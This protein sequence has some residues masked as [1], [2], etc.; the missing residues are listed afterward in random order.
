MT[1]VVSGQTQYVSSGVTDTGDLV[2]YG[3]VQVVLSG[4]TTINTDDFGVQTLEFDGVGSVTSVESGGVQNVDGGNSI[5]AVVLNGG[6]QN[7]SNGGFGLKDQIDVGGTQNLSGGEEVDALIYGIEDVY[8]GGVADSGTVSGGPAYLNIYSGGSG[9]YNVAKGAGWVAVYSG[10]AAFGTYV[11]SGGAGRVYSSGMTTSTTVFTQ[12]EEDVLFGGVATAT[13]V[14]SGGAAYIGQGGASSD[15]VIFS[16]GAEFVSGSANTPT[17]SSAGSLEVSSGGVAAFAQVQAFSS[18]TVD[19]GGVDSSG[20]VGGLQTVFGKTVKDV[21]SGGPANEYVSN[22][23]VTI[24]NSLI[25]Q[26]YEYVSSGGSASATTIAPLAELLVYS[27]GVASGSLVSGE[28]FLDVGGSSFKDQVSSG[29]FVDNYGVTTSATLFS[30]GS[31]TV[32]SGGT[33]SHTTIKVG[34]T[35]TVA[36]G[37]SDFNALDY[38]FQDVFGTATSATVSGASAIQ[39]VESGGVV[40]ADKLLAGASDLVFSGAAASSS[41]IGSGCFEYGFAGGSSTDARVSSGG[42]LNFT[43]VV[44]SA[45]VLSGGYL[46]INGG[47]SANTDTVASGGHE[48]VESGGVATA[49]LLHGSQTL[50]G[51]AEFA[52]VS[53]GGAQDVQSGG[54]AFAT[55]LYSVGSVQIESS[56][57][58]DYLDIYGGS[59]TISGGGESDYEY[60]FSGTET[61]LS[62]AVA[63][64]GTVYSGVVNAAPGAIVSDY[65]FSK[66]GTDVMFG[67]A[68]ESGVTVSSGATLDLVDGVISAGAPV[69]AG[70][71][72]VGTT[73]SGVTLLS[74]ASI[75]TVSATVLSGGSEVVAPGGVGSAT[76]VDGGGKLTVSANATASAAVVLSGGTEIF[77]TGGNDSGTQVDSGAIFRLVNAVVA[78]GATLKVGPQSATT[79][80]SG[81][82]LSGGADLVTLSAMVQSGGKE[83]V[84]SGGVASSTIVQSGGVENL[85]AGATAW[86]ATVLSGGELSGLGQLRAYLSIDSGGVASNVQLKA[87]SVIIDNGAIGYLGSKTSAV[88]GTLSGSGLLRDDGTGVLVV[89]GNASAFSGSAVISGGIIEL[90]NANALGTAGIAFA[91][92]GGSSAVLEID[93]VDRPTNGGTF[94]STLSNFSSSGDAVDL[95]NLT[96]HAGATASASAGLLKLTDGTYT[97]KFN[98]AGTSA[99]SYAVT[100]DGHGGTLIAPAASPSLVLQHAI[101]AFDDGGGSMGYAS[102][103]VVSGGTSGLLAPASPLK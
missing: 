55:Y 46:Q 5:S 33:A 94:A 99:T 77:F 68:S 86:S 59:A 8:S 35:E 75:K 1:E 51:E 40:I 34:A 37:G 103:Y 88:A 24:S 67:G 19:L 28:E 21:I 20:T 101:A 87:G 90:A 27:S 3:G 10:G 45:T 38:G 42:S 100:S 84:L 47:G 69:R 78:N 7:V 60:V 39:Y 80:L 4:G 22:G 91:A 14:S 26:G 52:I 49:T 76:T 16:G 57:L 53:S 9:N 41:F 92:P 72:T 43:G 65:S 81:A 2:D 79:T 15:D 95:V 12:G 31:A 83:Q 89:S 61:V 62:G 63:F 56:G 66:G 96:S 98:L 32:E 85:L 13:Q 97:A 82:T 50:F 48:D 70:K 36:S 23:G 93:A 74:G 11:S 102:A 44:S 30:R 25:D 18:E 6:V 54:L 71:V 17:V 64:S 29:G 58:A 73:L